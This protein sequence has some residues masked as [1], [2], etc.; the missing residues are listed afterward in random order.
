[1]RSGT[2]RERREGVSGREAALGPC[3]AGSSDTDWDPGP[4]APLG[5]TGHWC[6]F[7][8]V[9]D[10]GSGSVQTFI[11]HASGPGLG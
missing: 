9:H 2:E 4:L 8:G 10:E 6:C 7:L 11:E 3:L 1:M 5:H